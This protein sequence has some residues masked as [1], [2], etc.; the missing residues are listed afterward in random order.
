MKKLK[1]NH[2][3]KTALMTSLVTVS[4]VSMTSCFD[5]NDSVQ[6]SPVVEIP[7]A[8]A[9]TLSLRVVGVD[10][11]P[12]DGAT[13]EV[14]ADGDPDDVILASGESQITAAAGLVT[15]DL[16]E[17]GKTIKFKA[18][19]SNHFSNTSS[20]VADS[21]VDAV[22]DI[23]ITKKET[24]TGIVVAS[25]TG[26]VSDGL[27]VDNAKTEIIVP[28]NLRDERGDL[29]EGKVTLDVAHFNSEESDGLNSF[30]GGFTAQLDNP[31]DVLAT[32]IEG[33]G[34]GEAPASVVFKSAGFVAVELKDADGK[35]ITKFNNNT[36]IKIT[37]AIDP[38]AKFQESDGT[39]RAVKAG[40]IIPVWSFDADS[41]K[42]KY[43]TEGTV[44]A[45]SDGKLTVSHDATHLSYYNLD[46][47]TAANCTSTINFT[48]SSG[49]PYTGRLYGQVIA[50][51][52]GWSHSVSYPGDGTLNLLNAPSTFNVKMKLTNRA[53]DTV[54]T[55]PS[56]FPLCGTGATDRTTTLV[57]PD[58]TPP[59]PPVSVTFSADA[60][61][62]DNSSV[63][64]KPYTQ[65][66]I[67]IYDNSWRFIASL[68]TNTVGEAV[69]LLPAGSGY[70]YYLWDR[71]NRKYQFKTNQTISTTNNTV[72]FRI[73]K[74]CGST[75]PA[76]G[77][78]G[79]TG[80][81]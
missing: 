65:G 1:I 52:N 37:M 54:S 2:Y 33:G 74:T 67:Y 23:V 39:T 72:D 15:F 14:V 57:L 16:S 40:D 5:S 8:P 6:K 17:G 41:G 62:S 44:I 29:I 64:D 27:T 12:V 46:W 47:F 4:A 76:T 73:G 19:A 49:A 53:G 81:S 61:C 48:T 22:T 71:I 80:G 58:V 31:S 78:T 3:I 30:P 79:G 77:G 51:G 25:K 32:P 34:T 28:E 66:R 21:L 11:A 75:T 42:W 59:P 20:V 7:P 68:R 56:T 50:E 24:T 10:G 70:K 43:E 36:P 26:L 13:V 18:S 38:K 9:A 55:D 60:Y 63:A 69:R 35:N 45:G